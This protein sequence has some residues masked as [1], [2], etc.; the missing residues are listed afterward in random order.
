M[1]ARTYHARAA[2]AMLASAIECLSQGWYADAAT[3]LRNGFES[4]SRRALNE[5]R[6]SEYPYT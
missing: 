5:D 1:T 6:E 2:L 3:Y 4:H